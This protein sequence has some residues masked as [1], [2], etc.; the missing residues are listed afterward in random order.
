M[1]ASDNLSCFVDEMSNQHALQNFLNAIA[2]LPSTMVASLTYI[3]RLGDETPHVVK[4]RLSFHG[5]AAEVSPKV[6]TSHEILAERFRLPE[7]GLSPEEVISATINGKIMTPRGELAFLPQVTGGYAVTFTPFHP[8]GLALLQRTGVLQIKGTDQSDHWQ[9][10]LLDWALRSADTPYDNLNEL[11]I[12]FGMGNVIERSTVFEAV[13]P[14]IVAVDLSRQV[15]GVTARIG[16]LATK[17]IDRSKV[18]IGYRVFDKGIV[19]ARAAVSG[20]ILDWIEEETREVAATEIAIPP[21]SIVNCYAR[22]AGVTYHSGF[23]VDPSLA[24]N[25]RR[26]AYEK[27]DPGL[28]ALADM[29][30]TNE[31]KHARDVEPAVACLLWLLGFNTCHLGGTKSLQDGP[32][33]LGETPS[34]HVLVVECTIGTL[35]ADSKMPKLLARAA[36]IREQLSNAGRA[37]QRVLPVMVTTLS[38][39]KISSELGDAIANGVY[40]ITGDDFQEA[41]GRTLILP[42]ADQLFAEAEQSLQSFVN[43]G[44]EQP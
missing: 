30:A 2:G 4:A 23:I 37:Y 29:L 39:D 35:K 43:L 12:D 21:A 34:G 8:E 16:I 22:Y 31:R 38:R 20:E 44:S 1:L 25:S 41:I 18:S 9:N 27:F 10:P 14:Q 26:A 6:F 24:Q 40:V 15:T 11:C 28:A 42:H 5:T 13:A 3:A 19:V 33:I 32:D 17:G 7:I 36:A